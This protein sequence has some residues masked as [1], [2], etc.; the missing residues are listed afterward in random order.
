MRLDERESV[1]RPYGNELFRRDHR[2]VGEL[3]AM[4]A[5]PVRS[6]EERRAARTDLRTRRRKASSLL[7]T[8]GAE[9]YLGAP[10]LCH[11]CHGLTSSSLPQTMMS[12]SAR[13]ATAM[14]MMLP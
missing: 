2:G 9:T 14:E 7:F 6:K 12:D 10:R 8:M 4:P 11:Q 3:D 1:L 5:V 13:A